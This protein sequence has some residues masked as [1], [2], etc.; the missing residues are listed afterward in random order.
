MTD[1][2]TA[3]NLEIKIRT[4]VTAAVRDAIIINIPVIIRPIFLVFISGRL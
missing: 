3:E 1:V 4:A 2:P